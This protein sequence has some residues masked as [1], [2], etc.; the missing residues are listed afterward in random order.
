MKVFILVAFREKKE[1]FICPYVISVHQADI[2][3]KIWVN[4]YILKGTGTQYS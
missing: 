2:E 1:H 3:Q 4:N